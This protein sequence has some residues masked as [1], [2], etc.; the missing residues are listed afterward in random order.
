L[1]GFWLT[2]CG[3][4]RLCGHIAVHEQLG[5]VVASRAAERTWFFDSPS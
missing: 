3:W 2:G 5:H 4:Q 1:L